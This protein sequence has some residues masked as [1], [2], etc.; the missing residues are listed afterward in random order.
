MNLI[1]VEYYARV[2]YYILFFL[3]VVVYFQSFGN[4][5]ESS[6][7]I[8]SKKAIG[9]FLVFFIVIYIGIRDVDIIFVDMYTYALQFQAYVDGA[10]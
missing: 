2:Y 8:K 5:L 7:N 6:S 3:V 4:S 1:P 10:P 9:L